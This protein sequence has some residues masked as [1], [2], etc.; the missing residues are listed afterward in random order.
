MV[1]KKDEKEIENNLTGFEEFIESQKGETPFIPRGVGGGTRK[2]DQNFNNITFLTNDR[3][4]LTKLKNLL[5]ERLHFVAKF[6][7]GEKLLEE[8][9]LEI[10]DLRESIYSISDDVNSPYR[11]SLREIFDRFFKN[12]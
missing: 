10:S 12:S 7:Q 4:R 5:N 1:S 2:Q 11:K 3:A 8:Q 6:N 9:D